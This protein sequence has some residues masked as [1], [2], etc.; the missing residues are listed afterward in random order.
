MNPHQI[1]AQLRAQV[2]RDLRNGSPV[3]PRRMQALVADL[4]GDEQQDLIA[5]LRY[6]VLSG[7]FSTACSMDPPLTDGHLQNLSRELAEVFAPTLCT[8]IQPVLEGLLGID[9]TT[10]TTQVFAMNPE[11]V[12]TQAASGIAA[13]VVAS[14]SDK[15]GG[16]AATN[17]V[18]AFFSG[19]LLMTLAC[20]GLLVWQRQ[21]S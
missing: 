16:K 10:T 20:V 3:D 13:G 15:I 18:L 2:L 21:H 14:A 8:R 12:A 11:P 6:L 9:A 5:P 7:T 19:V 1:G 4:C 17:A